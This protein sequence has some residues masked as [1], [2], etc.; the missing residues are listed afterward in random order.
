MTDDKLNENP[1]NS[2]SHHKSSAIAIKVLALYVIAMA[3]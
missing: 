2:H 3:M 1:L